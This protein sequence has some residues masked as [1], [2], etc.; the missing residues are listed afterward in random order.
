MET[1]E[2]HAPFQYRSLQDNHILLNAISLQLGF[3]TNFDTDSFSLIVDSGASSTAT[4]CKDN[5]IEHIYKPLNGVTISGIRSGLNASGIGSV[6]Y[7][8]KD[9]DNNLIDL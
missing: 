9:D 2:F 4:P 5:F 6:L 1:D 8:M 3:S 7:K